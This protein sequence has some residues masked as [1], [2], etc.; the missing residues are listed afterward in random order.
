MTT[1]LYVRAT[2]NM[3]GMPTGRE[4]WIDAD[5]EEQFAPLLRERY[6]IPVDPPWYENPP[7][8]EEP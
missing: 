4:V 3:A 2:I 6:L 7:T 8:E 5:D 1:W